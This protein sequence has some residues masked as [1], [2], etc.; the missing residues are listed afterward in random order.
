MRS[1]LL[2]LALLSLLALPVGMTGFAVLWRRWSVEFSCLR[3][4]TT[5]VNVE[6][7]S[8]CQTCRVLRVFFISNASK[9]KQ[10]HAVPCIVVVWQFVHSSLQ[11]A[12]WTF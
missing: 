10:T 6:G 11:V 12:S 9:K 8:Y 7:L 2:L 3:R 4:M 5:A 1:L